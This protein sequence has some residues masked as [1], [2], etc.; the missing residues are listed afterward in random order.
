MARVSLRNF[1]TYSL[2][3]DR[4]KSVFVQRL[5]DQQSGPDFWE[6]FS[7]G[8]RQFFR[9]GERQ[10][11]NISKYINPLDVLPHQQKAYDRASESFKAFHKKFLAEKNIT[12]LDDPLRLYWHYHGTFVSLSVSL[13]LVVN[14]RKVY[15]K[16]LYDP[17]KDFTKRDALYFLSM[18]KEVYVSGNDPLIIILRLDNGL[19][20]TSADVLGKDVE[21][22]Q[23]F[24]HTQAENFASLWQKIQIQK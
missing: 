4:R 13:A 10:N 9:N 19:Y 11:E 16:Y 12:Y 14:G 21:R 8:V 2:L 24:L 18:I 17:D 6:L 1:I 20:Y 5:V 15:I 22:V 23:L 3:P 7:S